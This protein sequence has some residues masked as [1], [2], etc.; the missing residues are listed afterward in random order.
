MKI[1]QIANFYGPKSGGLRTCMIEIAKQYALNNI[2]CLQIVP[3]PVLSRITT[4]YAEVVTVPSWK[5]P[6]SGGYRIIVRT[7]LIKKLL[8]E[9]S[10][11]IIEINDRLTLIPIATWARKKGIKTSLFAH[12]ILSGVVKSFLPFLPKLDWL[13]NFY[14]RNTAQKFDHIVATT[15]F[16]AQ[17][18]KQIDAENLSIIPLGVDKK[19]FHPSRRNNN[20]VNH[21]AINMILC[22]R[23]SKEKNPEFAFKLVKTLLDH[24]FKVNLKVL[25]SGPLENK[26]KRKYFDLPIIFTGFIKKRVV[27]AEHLASADIVLAPG[28]NETFCLAALEAISCGTPVIASDKSALKEVLLPG[29]GFVVDDNLE[30]WMECVLVVMS[31]HEIRESALERSNSFSWEQTADKLLSLYQISSMTKARAA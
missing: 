24:G 18:F 20:A 8:K 6:F 22:S 19:I 26:L 3:G 10:P 28:P 21:G 11:E 13:V 25:G 9:F 15:K 29:A 1:A 14:N 16:A 17:E 23:L 4:S 27:I 30:N 7:S 2:E 5:I 31:N 12:E